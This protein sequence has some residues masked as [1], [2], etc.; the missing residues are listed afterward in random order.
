MEHKSIIENYQCAG[1]VCGSDTKCYEKG[2]NVEC[3]KHVVGTRI[4]GLGRIFLGMPKGFNR[5]GPVEDMGM[6]IFENFD[7]GWGYNK[8]NLPVWKHLDE[9]GNTLVRGISPRTNTPFL[10]VFIGDCMDR[11]SCLQITSSDLLEMD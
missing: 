1:C 6:Q 7:K 9:Y 11:I 5:Q 3:G 10:H 4:M 8:L 2:D